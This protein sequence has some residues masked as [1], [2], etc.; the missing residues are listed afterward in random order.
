LKVAV[1]AVFAF[2]Y[3]VFIG[4]SLVLVGIFLSYLRSVRLYR[5][6]DLEAETCTFHCFPKIQKL[7]DIVLRAFRLSFGYMADRKS[8]NFK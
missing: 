3:A 8:R 7:P 2:K 1:S 4:P 5:P 6:S